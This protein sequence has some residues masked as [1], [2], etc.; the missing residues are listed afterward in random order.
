[1]QQ[2]LTLLNECIQLKTFFSFSDEKKFQEMFIIK[3]VITILTG[4]VSVVDILHS[5]RKDESSSSAQLSCVK[6][7]TLK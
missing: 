7:K 3:H 5:E 2:S 1:M 4:I 6:P